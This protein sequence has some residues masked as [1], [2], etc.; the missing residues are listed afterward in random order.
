[1]NENNFKEYYYKFLNFNEK[2]RIICS[3]NRCKSINNFYYPVIISKFQDSTMY[4][5]APDYFEK[6]K[7]IIIEE[8][9]IKYNLFEFFQKHKMYFSIQDMYRMFK[10]NNSNTDIS[11]VIELDNK[12]KEQYFN[13]FEHS[14]DI[15]YKQE[16]W[17]KI[18]KYQYLNGIIE[19]NKFVSVGFVSN[20]DENGA[21]IVI[22]TKDKYRNRGYG[23]AIVEK[24]SRDLLEDNIIPIYW[25]N[26]ENK[27]SI[28]LAESIGFKKEAD[29][30]VVK[31]ITE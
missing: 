21:N 15:I 19:D 12:Y 10:N 22:Q 14:N 3:N 23:K 17:E 6:L 1:M 27:A 20:I 2:E 13:S 8:K 4:S 9:D 16:K 18:I 24:I 26:K 11:N 31:L 28:Q 7:E 29:E 30:I 25:V 5:I